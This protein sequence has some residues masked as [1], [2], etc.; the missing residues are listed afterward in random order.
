MLALIVAILWY[1]ATLSVLSNCAEIDSPPPVKPG[2]TISR[3]DLARERSN[4][5]DIRKELSTI[6]MPHVSAKI[7]DFAARLLRLLED[8]EDTGPFN[9]RFEQLARLFAEAILEQYNE[10]EVE[11]SAGSSSKLSAGPFSSSRE[12]NDDFSRFSQQ[13]C[14]LQSDESEIC[15]IH[16]VMCF[17]G[18]SPI[19]VVDRPITEPE[20]IND[21]T[22]S[23]QDFRYYEPSSHEYGGCMYA[24]SYDRPYNASWPIRPATDY[25]L[26][27]KRRRWGSANRNGGLFFKEVAEHVVWGYN[28]QRAE[29]AAAFA[30]RMEPLKANVRGGRGAQQYF[31]SIPA[32]CSCEKDPVTG[33]LPTCC[34]LHQ[35]LRNEVFH[36]ED[37]PD[38]R[39]SGRTRVGNLTMDWLDGP[40]WLAGLDGQWSGNPY[41]WFAKMATLYDAQRVNATPGFGAHP[42]DGYMHH[43]IKWEVAHEKSVYMSP[44]TS[45]R[46]QYKV[47][48]Q[49]PIPPMEFV[50]FTGDGA[51]VLNNR[52]VLRDWFASVLRLSTQPNTKTYFNDLLTAYGDRTKHKDT[53]WLC[54]TSGVIPG[55]KNKFFTG[56][57][58]AWM[59]RQYAYQYTRI[60]DE[61][62]RSHPVYPPRHITIL[63]RQGMNGRGF[64]NRDQLI[65]AVAATGLPYKVVNTMGKM[66]FRDQVSMMAHTGILIAPHGAALANAMFLPAHSAVIELFP[67]LMKKNTYRHLCA[68]M[69]L[70]YFPVY[71]WELLPLNR[72]EFYGVELMGEQYFYDKCV[73]TNIT[74]YDALTEHAC[75]AMSK[76]VSV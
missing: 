66:S 12:A 61:G 27:L 8:W 59:F 42:A 48:S 75:N 74:S 32:G 5:E 58:D 47:G 57:A 18:K 41:H 28:P 17:D 6:T 55:A 72:T 1:F 23:C 56:R 44:A 20:R 38:L 51:N 24:Y 9:E 40:L 54:T 10:D 34:P 29:A 45:N 73:K 35:T 21:F 3:E 22:H 49:W 30:A 62:A 15:F 2:E 53:R 31:G 26:P 13:V 76:N 71:S 69:D 7:S 70:H 11:A 46:V 14:Y 67:Y 60:A 16:N 39:L 36:H 25:P 68:M 43:L 50:A 64:F 63:D 4:I 37:I 65:A 19:V 33:L 52:T